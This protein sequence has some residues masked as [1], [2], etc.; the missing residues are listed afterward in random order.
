ML[1]VFLAVVKSGDMGAFFAGKLLGKRKLVPWLSPGKTVEGAL[2]ALV[3]AAGVSVGLMALW[4]RVEQTLGP[5]PVNVAQALVFGIVM[6]IVGHLGDL[7]ES[8]IKRDVGSKDSAQVVPAFGG[9]LDLVDSPL[10]A[11]PVAW[12]LLTLWQRIG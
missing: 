8:L 5:R 4:S 3:L 11:A 1:I 9:L 6:A 10:F 7:T 12:W 2:G